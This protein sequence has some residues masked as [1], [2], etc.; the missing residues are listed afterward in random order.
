M[1]KNSTCACKH[2]HGGGGN[3]F[4]FGVIVGAALVFLLAT[5][6]GK[7]ILKALTEGG[8]EG[9]SE[10]SELLSDA[11]D[12]SEYEDEYA[13]EGPQAEQAT[14]QEVRPA[15]AHHIKRLFRG[16]KR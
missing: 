11:E 2:N 14:P 5:K 10:L 9:V 1:E 13:A 7:Q 8:F 6:K 16:V 12:D 15:A 4:L 3:G